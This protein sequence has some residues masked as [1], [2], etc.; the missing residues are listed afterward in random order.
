MIDINDPKAWQQLD[1]SDPVPL[2]IRSDATINRSRSALGKKNN[3]D[4]KATMRDVASKRGP[5]HNQAVGR[6]C[7]ETRN[8]SYQAE[9]NARPEVQAR[10][11]K[12]MSQHVRTTEHNVNNAQANVRNAQDPAWHAALMDG[13]AKR[14]RA[15]HTPYG[16]FPSLNAAA[17]Y[18][19][20]QGLLTNAV[21]KFEKWKK[22]DPANYYFEEKK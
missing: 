4:F 19:T 3:P 21:K 10:I 16:V 6:G 7:R 20:E 8:N 11:S 14:D 17:R 5:E 18:V 9:S 15:F 1:W 13:L 12:S 22:T 2:K